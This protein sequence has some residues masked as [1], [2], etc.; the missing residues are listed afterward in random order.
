M[1]DMPVNSPV[2]SNS[3]PIQPI[4]GSVLFDQEVARRNGLRGRGNILS[5]CGELDG[6]V[7]LGG[8]ERG[9]VVGISAEDEGVGLLVSFLS[10]RFLPTPPVPARHI[11]S[12]L[13]CR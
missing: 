10:F 8:F 4:P 1:E 6:S 3:L 5:G 2:G 12:T 7:L 11:P 13:T 9:C